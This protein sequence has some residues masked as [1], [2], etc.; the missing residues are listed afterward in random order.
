MP[1][2]RT[3]PATQ[4]WPLLLAAGWMLALCSAGSG[5]SA[6]RGSSPARTTHAAIPGEA[7][8]GGPVAQLVQTAATIRAPLARSTYDVNGAGLTCAVLD[9]GARV[10]HVDFA[11]R[12]LAT[13]NFTSDNGGDP[14]N[15]TDV[16]GHGTNSAGVIAANDIHTGLAPGANLAIVKVLNNE[17]AGDSDTVGN[18]LQ[19]VIENHAALNISVVS[20]SVSDNQNYL[21][22]Q[23]FPGDPGGVRAKI[24]TL[25][26]LNIPVVV[27]AGNEYG[28]FESRQGMSWPAIFPETVSVGGTYDANVGAD[29][30]NGARA[31]TTARDRILPYSQ[32]LHESVNPTDRTDIFAPGA[33]VTSSGNSGN[34][35][36]STFKGTSESAPVVSGV[37]LLIQQYFRRQ[38]GNLPTV[39]QV[40]AFLRARAVTI[41]DGDDED[42]NV[43][44]TGLNFLRLDAVRVLDAVAAGISGPTLSNCRLNP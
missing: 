25:R 10:T 1:R 2:T 38:T 37:I 36:S 21:R 29:Q 23:D 39:D 34:R 6:V 42:D 7:A 32:R 9:T 41:N 31:N 19:W 14:T 12:V 4:R 20:M 24:Q 28:R 27:S 16:D 17:G 3:S 43:Q 22:H 8:G 30:L 15:V 13:R 35:A 18:G 5:A 26:A 11:D 40:E 33:E 44:N